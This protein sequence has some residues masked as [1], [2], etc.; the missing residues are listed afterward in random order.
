[1]ALS[2]RFIN[3]IM[4][5]VYKM[6]FTPKTWAD[7][8]VEFPGRRTLTPVT[9]DDYSLVDVSLAEGTIYAAGQ[10]WNAANMN[11]LESRIASYLNTTLQVASGSFTPTINPAYAAATLSGTYF[12]IARLCHVTIYVRG[13]IGG[14][15]TQ[16][17]ISGLPFTSS[18]AEQHLPVGY[19]TGFSRT[20]GKIGVIAANSKDVNMWVSSGG[21]MTGLDHQTA[22]DIVLR[23]SGVYRIA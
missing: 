22:G 3:F 7:R 18:G 16:M 9:P 21:T 2:E 12:R 13:N 15:G 20:G 4:K 11:D 6:P 17:V 10:E 1:M 8:N 23:I 19:N 14:S 5:E